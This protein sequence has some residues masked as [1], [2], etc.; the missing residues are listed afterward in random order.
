MKP[1]WLQWSF[2]AV[3][4]VSWILVGLIVTGVYQIGW[5]IPDRL[6]QIEELTL[7]A[8]TWESRAKELDTYVI[9]QERK[10]KVA[11][12]FDNLFLLIADPDQVIDFEALD[13]YIKDRKAFYEAK[14]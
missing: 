8:N 3:L 12:K 11:T 14:K 7:K 4:T 9:E 10:Y 2:F 1:N 6:K 13:K 5:G